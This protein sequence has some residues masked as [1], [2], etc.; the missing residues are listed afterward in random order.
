ML[1]IQVRVANHNYSSPTSYW[2]SHLTQAIEPES[3]VVR[4]NP[5]VRQRKLMRRLRYKQTH[6]L[7]V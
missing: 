1:S 2:L 5:K 3:I 6:P 4:T 7:F